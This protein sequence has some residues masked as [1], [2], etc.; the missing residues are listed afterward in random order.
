MQSSGSA[1]ASLSMCQGSSRSKHGSGSTGCDTLP[2]LLAQNP[3]NHDDNAGGYFCD[4]IN[5]ICSC[6]P[7]VQS[8]ATCAGS[9]THGSPR[10]RWDAGRQ[11]SMSAEALG[12]AHRYRTCPL[13]RDPETRLVSLLTQQQRGGL[14]AS[15]SANGFADEDNA[16]P[17]PS[18][19]TGTPRRTHSSIAGKCC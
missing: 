18:A 15:G 14:A 1:R 8:D 11:R 4:G 16:A 7:P 2:A 5:V 10:T 17:A 19:A 13:H 12:Q 9:S 3:R 6:T